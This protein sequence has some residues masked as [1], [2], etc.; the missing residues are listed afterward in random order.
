VAIKSSGRNRAFDTIRL[1]VGYCGSDTMATRVQAD[2][3]LLRD[4]RDLFRLTLDE[5]D[6]TGISR[7]TWARIEQESE[8]SHRPG[9]AKRIEVIRRL[10]EQ[11]G[12]M[13]YREARAWAIRPLPRRGKSPRDLISTSLF[14]INEVLR[15]LASRDDFVVT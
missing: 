1:I 15:Y 2:A 12:Q 3:D 6:A 14:G 9:V 5:V 10:M 13:P 4:F 8:T 7:S 11:V